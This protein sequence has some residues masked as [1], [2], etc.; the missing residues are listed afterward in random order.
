M[1]KTLLFAY[2]ILSLFLVSCIAEEAPQV[3]QEAATLTV[4]LTDVQTKTY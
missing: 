1:N 3:E 4:G 2:A